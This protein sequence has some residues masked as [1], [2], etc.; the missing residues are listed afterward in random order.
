[1]RSIKIVAAS[2][3]LLAMSCGAIGYSIAMHES[4]SNL[5]TM[6]TN[7]L[8]TSEKTEGGVTGIMP[9]TGNASDDT[10]VTE[11][12]T[13]GNIKEKFG[14]TNSVEISPFYNIEQTSNFIFHFNSKVDAMKAVTVHTDAK[15]N[16][17]SMVKQENKG[18]ETKEGKEDVVVMPGTPVLGESNQNM[19]GYAPIYYLC[20]RYDLTSEEVK[21]LDEPIIVP[22]TVKSPAS[23][24]NVNAYVNNDGQFEIKWNPVSNAVKY[25]IYSTKASETNLTKSETAYTGEKP[26]LIATVDAETNTF[27]EFYENGNVVGSNGYVYG[28]NFN[29]LGA[30]YVTTVDKG[31]NESSYSM[32]IETS[33]FN[34]QMP[35]TF[36]EQLS[37][38]KNNGVTTRLPD[39]AVVKMYSG[40]SK[41]F[42]IHY[43][44]INEENGVATYEYSIS[45]TLL[46]GTVKYQ[47]EDGVYEQNIISDAQFSSVMYDVEN[48]INT[49]PR[50]T[51]NTVNSS[52]Y[53]DIS[54][55][56]FE[57]DGT[58]I[59]NETYDERIDDIQNKSE[60]VIIDGIYDTE[61]PIF[62]DNA[63]EEYLAI[64]LTDVQ[65]EISTANFP[66]LQNVYNLLDVLY[67]VIYQNPYV[68]SV[69]S[70]AYS[71]DEQMLYITYALNID[72]IKSQQKEI[73][74][75]SEE[76]VSSII[77]DDM[78]E[79]AKVMAIWNYL[80][81]N[82]VYDENACESAEVNGFKNVNGSENS[83]STYGIM[84]QNKGVCQSYMH[85]MKLLC[86]L[87]NVECKSITGY[88]HN[89]IP[90]GWNAVKI[91]GN[92]YW[93]D[94]T[95]NKTNS[96]LPYFIFLT[97]SEFAMDSWGYVT[98]DDYLLD[99]ESN[100]AET[101]EMELDYY[102]K[103]GLYANSHKEITNIVS[104]KIK[105]HNGS[106]YIKCSFN[107][108]INDDDFAYGIRDALV[109]AGYSDDEI[110]NATIGNNGQ[111]MIVNVE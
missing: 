88:L 103:R 46:T 36:D 20:I 32:P 61:Y 14:V 40:T 2:M 3:L 25:N 27:V 26:K 31:G 106:L 72:D 60:K 12:I 45:G 57:I 8:D 18:Y 6:E 71:A 95:N 73:K 70:F 10:M 82:T 80:E 53:V 108:N 56:D 90:H 98:D 11:S 19:W 35:K 1:M 29:E 44:K 67:K 51:V 85:T 62:A 94:V 89:T 92:W 41:Q 99:N 110:V 4:G 83:F 49:I 23:I 42:P 30:Y 86:E 93:I 68:I 38:E 74:V 33:E 69:K 7:S 77:S 97:S 84:C 37:F 17:E 66:K 75:K 101:S 78:D 87:S 47:N 64:C 9:K 76:I 34:N 65:T 28:E 13:V 48:N 5:M 63:E 43:N 102:Y 81:E 105:E 55:G 79:E 24:P 96:G 59:K 100:F 39:T 52:E 107:P 50:N 91:N 58:L 21:A 54:V 111:M 22:F 16:K 109:S 104:N 15:C